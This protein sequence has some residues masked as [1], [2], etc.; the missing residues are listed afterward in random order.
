MEL[1]GP[2]QSIKLP[3]LEASHFRGFA[4]NSSSTLSQG[5]AVQDRS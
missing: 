4:I 2:I 3:T 5:M 1:V